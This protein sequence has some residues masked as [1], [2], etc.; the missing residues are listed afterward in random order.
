MTSSPGS[1]RGDVSSIEIPFS[2]CFDTSEDSDKFYDEIR[3]SL[4]NQAN[5]DSYIINDEEII[6]QDKTIFKLSFTILFNADISKDGH[7]TTYLKIAKKLIND[8]QGRNSSSEGNKKT[9]SPKPVER[10][11]SQ[12]NP[13][14]TT[15]SPYFWT[16][17]PFLFIIGLIVSIL[18][19]GNK[20]DT[21]NTKPQVNPSPQSSPPARTNDTNP[22][23]TPSTQSSS[24]AR[25]Q[26]LQRDRTRSN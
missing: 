7:N 5:I 9:K 8:A 10:Q 17:V 19:G 18:I 2:R 21:D 3:Q 23:P 16:I 25:T 14:P 4:K 24:P 20:P 1:G 13:L 6:F 15:P 12:I 22:Q 11:N 26:S